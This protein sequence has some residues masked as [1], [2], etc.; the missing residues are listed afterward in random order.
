MFFKALTAYTLT[1]WFKVFH[2]SSKWPCVHVWKKQLAE[3]MQSCWKRL[4]KVWSQTS[5]CV[6]CASQ[7]CPLIS[8]TLLSHIWEQIQTFFL[9]KKYCEIYVK[10]RRMTKFTVNS[11]ETVAPHAW[12]IILGFARAFCMTDIETRWC[13]W[14]YSSHFWCELMP[15]A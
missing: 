4:Q 13:M 3:R 7:A 10:Y 2:E 15:G 11:R 1:I 8:Q 5:L 9:K 6:R 12:P 14:C